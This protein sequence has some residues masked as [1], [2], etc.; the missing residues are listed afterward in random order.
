MVSLPSAR[1]AGSVL[2]GH[3]GSPHLDGRFIFYNR[4]HFTKMYKKGGWRGPQHVS[5]SIAEVAEISSVARP[6]PDIPSISGFC[7]C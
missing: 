3:A 6:A 1:G 4:S 2:E 7:R 5:V